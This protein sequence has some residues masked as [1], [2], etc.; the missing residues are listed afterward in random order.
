MEKE[1]VSIYTRALLNAAKPSTNPNTTTSVANHFFDVN[2]QVS[3][4]FVDTI[5]FPRALP[6]IFMWFGRISSTVAYRYRKS[7]LIIEMKCINNINIL[8][9]WIRKYATSVISASMLI[10]QY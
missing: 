9:P 1:T 8:A 5:H 2:S 4:L 6:Q 10:G 7:T 3:H